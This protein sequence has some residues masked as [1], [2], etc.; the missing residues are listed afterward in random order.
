MR[1][2]IICSILQ[3]ALEKAK[4]RPFRGRRTLQWRREMGQNFMLAVIWN[5]RPAP[6]T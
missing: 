3:C 6:G 5:R 4:S 1:I 2:C